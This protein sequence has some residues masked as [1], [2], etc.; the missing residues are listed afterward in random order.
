MHGAWRSAKKVFPVESGMPSTVITSRQAR[1]RLAAGLLAGLAVM[2]VARAND[3]MLS[4]VLIDDSN[5]YPESLSAS[6]DGTLYIGSM[7]GIIFRAPP[8]RTKAEAW[9]QPTPANGLLTIFGVL[10]DERAHVLWVCSSPNPLRTPAAIGTAALMAFDLKTG[11]QKASYPFPEPS[12]VCNDVTLAR[13]GT[14]YASD[15]ANGRILKLAPKAHSLTVWA[16]DDRLKGI[17]GI[18]MSAD[19][20]LYVNNVRTGQLL[21]VDQLRG[22]AAGA[23]TPLTVSTPLGGPDGFRLIHDRTFLLAEGTAGRVDEVT[24]NGKN[25]DVR[26]LRAGLLSPP[27]VTLVGH[28]VYAL[29]GKIGYLIDPKIK[30]QDTGAFVVQYIPLPK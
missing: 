14:A 22:G 23:I 29:E 5:V 18:V 2:G 8:G 30:G 11:S 16:Q 24:I 26:V 20:T 12:S 1:G 13:D 7:K 27:G 25:A 9:I 21:Q 17:D 15:T 28:T 10:V 6:R 19:Q 4:D 3:A